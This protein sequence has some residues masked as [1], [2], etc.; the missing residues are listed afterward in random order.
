MKNLA[1]IILISFIVN[2]LAKAQHPSVILELQS[3]NQGVLAPRMT[4]T[5][6]M[7]IS[8]LVMGL[9]VYQIDESAGF[10]FYNGSDWVLLSSGITSVDTMNWNSKQDEL[11]GNT[12]GEMLYW[13]GTSWVAVSPGEN[14]QTLTFCNGVPTW[15]PCPLFHDVTSVTGK[16]WM[17]RNLGATQ[18]ATSSTDEDGFGDYYQWGRD[19]DGH[20]MKTSDGTVMLSDS[21]VPGHGNFILTSSTPFDWRAPQNDNLW[22]GVIGINNPCPSG[23]RLP[24]GEEWDEES[25]SWTS[26]DAAGA[27]A[28]PL[29]LP[30]S[31][32]RLLD[33]SL[34]DQ[35]SNGAF[36]SSTPSMNETTILAMDPSQA[37][38]LTAP[39]GVGL[40]VRCIKD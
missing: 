38:L 1:L 37:A 16:V 21:D 25:L 5:Q 40:A 17:D 6:R 28:S 39:R 15:G 13:N 9:L 31:G 4:E 10:Y 27:Y 14:D 36:W 30:L 32:I 2:T 18:V 22:Q 24:T 19:T 29:K 11:P 26:N 3:T 12:P 7:D 23:Y 34:D 20:Q 8:P 35:G 33:G